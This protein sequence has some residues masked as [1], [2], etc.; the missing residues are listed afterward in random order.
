MK[1]E[2]SNSEAENGGEKRETDS[3]DKETAKGTHKQKK[4]VTV[5][6]RDL[7]F[8]SHQWE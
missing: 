2:D 8:Q 3:T 6:T 4:A 1:Q 7:K 5:R